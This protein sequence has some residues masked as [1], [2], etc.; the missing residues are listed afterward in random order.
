MFGFF[1]KPEAPRAAASATSMLSLDDVA[2][3]R[4]IEQWAEAM[5]PAVAASSGVIEA[6]FAVLLHGLSRIIQARQDPDARIGQST[7]FEVM[8][9]LRR[10]SMDD[11][12]L[13]ALSVCAALRHLAQRARITTVTEIQQSSRSIVGDASLTWGVERG[14]LLAKIEE[15]GRHNQSLLDMVDH[16][17]KVP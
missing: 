12:G 9:V 14:I 7:R 11:R 16:L 1:H 10:E 3:L 5:R 17:A 15:M 8:D 13:D 2:L 6:D 4:E